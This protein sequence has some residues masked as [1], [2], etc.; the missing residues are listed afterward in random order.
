MAQTAVF[1]LDGTLL[2][3]DSTAFWLLNLLFSSWL[4]VI[5]AV[6]TLPVTGPLIWFRGSRRIGA[7]II[8]WIA[9]LGRDQQAIESSIHDFALDFAEGSGG[10]RWRHAG[11][12]TLDRHLA[13]G[14]RVI[15][16]TA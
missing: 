6:L 16:V 2:A 5:A 1:D 12:E 4:R 15:V 10:L 3:G 13:A 7:S 9:S 11:L 8:L 14:D